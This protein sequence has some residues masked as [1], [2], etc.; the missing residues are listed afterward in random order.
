MCTELGNDE[1]MMAYVEEAGKTSLC[2]VAT[3]K[4]CSEKETKY[5]ASMG[6]KDGAEVAKQLARLEGMAGSSMK[7]DLK[8]KVSEGATDGR[9][10]VRTTA[11]ESPEARPYGVSWPCTGP[12]IT[13]IR[14]PCGPSSPPSSDHLPRMHRCTVAWLNQRIKILRQLSKAS[15][16]KSEL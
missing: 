10:H 12:S 16:T 2:S 13:F 5:I 3:S 15:E 6:G 14:L 7:P 11:K 4:G 9:T 1:Y 8:G